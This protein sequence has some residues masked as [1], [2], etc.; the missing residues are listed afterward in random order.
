M[1]RRTLSRINRLLGRFSG[2]PIL[3]SARVYPPLLTARLTLESLDGRIVPAN[4]G[5]INGAGSGLLTVGPV[6]GYAWTRRT[7]VGR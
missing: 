5:W 1:L 6:A 3:K 7:P 2:P 4:L